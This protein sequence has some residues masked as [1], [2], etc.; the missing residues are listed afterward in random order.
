MKALE[1]HAGPGALARLRERGLR[2]DDVGAVPAAAGGP[3]GLVL[4][5]LDRFV[6]GDWLARG[7]R[8]VHLLGASIGAW[9]MATACLDGVDAAFAQ[10]ADDYIHQTYEH[11]PGKPPVND[12][13]M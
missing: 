6:F 7:T 2:P 9:R 3:K 4:N 1:I 5:P 13:R 8:T 11:A 12:W 10:L